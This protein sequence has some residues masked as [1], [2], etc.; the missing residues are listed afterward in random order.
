M[1]GGGW[2]VSDRERFEAFLSKIDLAAYREKYSAIKLVELDMPREIQAIPA[3]YRD[4]WQRREG[5]PKFEDFYRSYETEKAEKIEANRIK[6]QFSHETFYLGLPARIYR[7]WASLLTQIQ[8]G[9][10]V[11]E[12]YGAGKVEMSADLDWRGID[13]R[14]TT[15]TGI[16]NI[17][18]K[19]Q[20]TSREVRRAWPSSRYGKKIIN[21]L[22]EVAPARKTLK[23]GKDSSSYK[24]WKEEWQGKLTILENGFVI[25]QRGMF[26][27]DD[28]EIE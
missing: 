25:F 26:E 15:A 28:S 1:R 9:Y 5:W 22:Y 2:R 24:R 21:I 19:K 3:L 13:F 23:N 6:W 17:Q 11:E 7:T 8:G 20:T 27:I 16:R 4:Y 14:I 18:I 12:M 10:V